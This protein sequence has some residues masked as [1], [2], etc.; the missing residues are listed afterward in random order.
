MRSA[1]VWMIALAIAITSSGCASTPA[2]CPR[3]VAPPSVVIAAAP[4]KDP[5]VA[6]LDVGVLV[7]DIS[8]SDTAQ[9]FHISDQLSQWSPFMHKQ[10]MRWADQEHLLGDP[11]KIALAAHRAVRQRLH[12]GVLDQNFYTTKSLQDALS[13]AKAVLSAEDFAVEKNLFETMT[14]LILPFIE[15]HK[16]ETVALRDRILSQQDKLKKMLEDFVQFAQVYLPKDHVPLW[17]IASTDGQA[18]GGGVNGGQMVVESGRDSVNTLLHESLHFVLNPKRPEIEAAAKSC[19]AGLDYETLNEGIAYA[20]SPGIIGNRDA[21][22]QTIAH[23]ASQ[24]KPVD[25]PYVR[26][27]RLGKRLTPLL[28]KA[29]IDKTTLATMLP[30]ACDEW[31]KVAATTWP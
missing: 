1:L 3:V 5:D 30:A 4:E 17:L 14:P 18:G 6:M 20:L 11:Q 22:D 10:Y 21:I 9:I 12:Y 31:K 2:P 25:D 29:L 26:F 19:G 15:K 28:E 13:D 24:G 7:Y 27:N 23:L 16:A 8:I